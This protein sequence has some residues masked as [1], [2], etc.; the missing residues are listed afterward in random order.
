M[1]T[2][3]ELQLGAML[4]VVADVHVIATLDSMC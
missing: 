4:F 3:G 1:Y 2:L